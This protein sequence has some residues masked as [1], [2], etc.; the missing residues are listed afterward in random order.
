MIENCRGS[1][2]TGL[3]SSKLPGRT[4]A[5]VSVSEDVMDQDMVA[6]KKDVKD[7]QASPTNR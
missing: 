2:Q 7:L 3:R 5:I 4:E 1:D 6:I